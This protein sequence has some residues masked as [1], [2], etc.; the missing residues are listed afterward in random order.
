MGV[1]PQLNVTKLKLTN[2]TKEAYNTSIGPLT[3]ADKESNVSM[4][5]NKPDAKHDL[6]NVS[7]IA[8]EELEEMLSA[9][10]SNDKVNIEDTLSAV[11]N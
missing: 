5:D 6:I 10:D 9:C 3:D 1:D 11:E 8:A 4:K 2:Q 7:T